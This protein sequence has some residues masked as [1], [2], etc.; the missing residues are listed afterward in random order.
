MY[1]LKTISIFLIALFSVFVT[2]QVTK[3]E[4]VCPQGYTCTL[5]KDYRVPQCPEGYICIPTKERN[6]TSVSTTASD[7]KT[8]TTVWAS[9]DESNK[10]YI[11][12]NIYGKSFDYYQIVIGNSTLNKEV[13]LVKKLDKKKTEFVSEIPSAFLEQVLVGSEARYTNYVKVNAVKYEWFS[14]VLVNTFKSAEFTISSNGNIDEEGSDNSANPAIYSISPSSGPIG[15]KVQIKGYQ[16]SGFEGD[17]DVY[18]ERSDGKVVILTDNFGTYSKTGSDAMNFV[19][20][21]PCQKG[22]TIYGRYSGI[23]STCDYVALTPGKYKVYVKPYGQ[24]SNVVEFTITPGSTS[25]SPSSSPVSSVIKVISPMNGET[26]YAGNS[27]QIRWYDDSDAGSKDI[28]LISSNGKTISIANKIFARSSGIDDSYSYTWNVYNAIESGQYKIKICKSNSYD[29]G[30]SNGYFTVNSGISGMSSMNGRAIEVQSYPSRIAIGKGESADIARYKLQAAD[31]DLRVTNI[32]LDFDVRLW[33]YANSV[34]I[35]DDSG[36]VIASKSFTMSDFSELV[37]GSNYRLSIPVN[38]VIPKSTAKYFTVNVTTLSTS[39]RCLSGGCAINL[40]NTEVRSVENNGNTN[41][42]KDD[43]DRMFIYGGSSAN[44]PSP[45]A[46]P[47]IDQPSVSFIYPNTTEIWYIGDTKNISWQY[48]NFYSSVAGDK[49]VELVLVPMDG[50]APVTLGT[51]TYPYGY[52]PLSIYRQ[53]STGKDA[54]LPGSYKLKLVCRSSNV[55][56]FRSC[57]AEMPGYIYVKENPNATPSPTPKS[58]PVSDS[59]NSLIRAAVIGAVRAL[60]DR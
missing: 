50:R 32:S 53:T 33:Q 4:I 25:I 7:S 9:V 11:K 57:G 36:S 35:K 56:G 55:D 31:S 2:S 26:L 40:I 47:A 30:L 46:T 48:S 42:L 21:E 39:D 17:L 28:S 6:T 38:Y 8:P 1:K 3:A 51:Y 34:T 14:P 23:P 43:T 59:D 49:F 58:M 20:K 5:I 10:L 22:Q 13:E 27:Y 37:V 24:K 16:L 15:T 12:W 44:S 19:I 54:W 45:S 60:F 41:T 29:C 52:Q 18:F